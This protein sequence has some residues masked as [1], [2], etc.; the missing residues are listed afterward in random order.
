MRLR[1]EVS[2]SES[3]VGRGSDCGP[4][5][6]PLD[7]DF[8]SERRRYALGSLRQRMRS[9]TSNQID[10]PN[11]EHVRQDL[12]RLECDIA[13]SPLDLPDVC[14]V[15]ARAVREHILGPPLFDPEC[16]HLRSDLFLD[17]LHQ[18]GASLVLPILVI[19]SRMRRTQ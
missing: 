16:P 8:I 5:G 7:F 12:E 1:V 17:G 18:C 6:A 10:N 4:E 19:T 15:Q 14:P 2:G 9:Q 3:N 11:V 13:L